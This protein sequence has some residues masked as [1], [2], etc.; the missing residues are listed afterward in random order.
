M[1]DYLFYILLLILLSLGVH[2]LKA[3]D[4]F[5]EDE[6]YIEEE[7][8]IPYK[9]LPS[10]FTSPTDTSGPEVILS[11]TVDKPALVVTICYDDEYKGY[12]CKDL[13]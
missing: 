3:Q 12:Y 7:Y 6:D 9:P 10:I 13:P 11:N 1:R 2:N 5:L 4:D 8:A